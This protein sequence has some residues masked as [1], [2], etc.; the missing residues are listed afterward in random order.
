MF[1][2]KIPL[3]THNGQNTLSMSET[4][5]WLSQLESRT[6]NNCNLKSVQIFCKQFNYCFGKTLFMLYAF[7]LFLNTF[8]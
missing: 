7:N 3:Q 2:G 8:L 5:N 6:D 1:W 4:L